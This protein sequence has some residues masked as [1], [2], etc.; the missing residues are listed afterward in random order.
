MRGIK[1]TSGKVGKKTMG[2]AVTG[3]KTTASVIAQV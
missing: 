2:E 1:Y 3:N